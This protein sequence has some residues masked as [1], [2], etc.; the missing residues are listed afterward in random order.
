MKKQICISLSKYQKLIESKIKLRILEEKLI[1]GSLH[2]TEDLLRIIGSNK[3]V[4][5]ADEL[6]KRYNERIISKGVEE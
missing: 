2:T 1:S 6:E 5:K 4:K 3:A